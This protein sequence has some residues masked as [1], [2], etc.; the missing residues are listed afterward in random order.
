MNGHV[1]NHDSH[2]KYNRPTD[3]CV[4]TSW[5][6]SQHESPHKTAVGMCCCLSSL[7]AR[8]SLSSSLSL[9]L[10]LPFALGG[11]VVACNVCNQCCYLVVVCGLS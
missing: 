10:T 6:A 2:C 11:A 5:S 8:F 9:S 3:S 4:F 1:M 7:I